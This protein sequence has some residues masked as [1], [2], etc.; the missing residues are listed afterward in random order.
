MIP[1]II[2][3]FW[4]SGTA[5]PVVQAAL[6]SWAPLAA[7]G[8]TIRLLSEHDAA[9]RAWALEPANARAVAAARAQSFAALSDLVRLSFVAAY[10]GVWM[11]ASVLEDWLRGYLPDAAGNPPPA[12]A[13]CPEIVGYHLPLL[14]SNPSFPVIESWMFAAPRGSPFVRAWRDHFLHALDVGFAGYRALVQS[15][16]VAV[17]PQRIYAEHGTYLT[18]H[19]AAQVAMQADARPVG[20]YARLQ[21]ATAGPDGPFQMHAACG[22]STPCFTRAF[23]AALQDDARESAAASRHPVDGT[24]IVKVRGWDANFLQWRR[25]GDP[26]FHLYGASERWHLRG[27]TY[28]TQAALAVV[29]LVALVLLAARVLWRRRR[30]P[31]SSDA[32]VAHVAH[33]AL[34]APQ[35]PRTPQPQQTRAP[36]ATP[37][38]TSRGAFQ[39]HA[40]LPSWLLRTPR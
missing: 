18:V 10:G 13:T 39:A 5:P 20:A 35:Q 15:G 25:D 31:S 12:P 19:V 26:R 33:A 29:L 28:S 2:F 17:D 9:Y 21:D 38:P 1:R 4:H 14:Q 34:G 32:H 24:R 16:A 23:S 27:I 30:P 36:L 3:S 11:D 8:W 22:W 7:R 6:D 40:P 37:R